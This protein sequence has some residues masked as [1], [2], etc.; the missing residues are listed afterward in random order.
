MGKHSYYEY[1]EVLGNRFF[2][3]V[4]LPKAEGKFPTV[5][6][7]NPYVGGTVNLDEADILSECL[8]ANRAYLDRGYAVV[9]QHTR[10]QG[11]ST[12]AFVPYIHEREDTLAL[13]EWIRGRDF[14]N[15]ELYPVGGSYTASLHYT[16]APFPPDIKGAVFEVQDYD[17]YRLWYRNGQMRAG[18]ANWHF[19]LYKNKCGLNKKFNMDSFSSLPLA[20]LSERALGD[21]AEDFEEMLAAPNPRDEFWST[22]YGGGEAYGATDNAGIPILLTTGYND[23]YVGGVFDMW[24]RMGEETRRQSALLV[25]PYNHGDSYDGARGIPFPMGRR[26]EA[27]GGTYA[28]DW[29]DN[30]RLGT[31]LPYEKGV[32]TYY[33]AFEDGWKSDFYSG[34]VSDVTVP[35]GEGE[36]ILRYDPKNPPAFSEEGTRWA[37]TAGEG[38]VITIDTAPFDHDT[39]V[40]GRMRAEISLSADCPDTSLY[41]RLS[42]NRGDLIYVLRHD[43]T[44]IGYSVGGYRPNEKITLSF[45]FDEYAF[46]IRSGDRLRVDIASTDKNTYVLHTNKKGPY[47]LQDES[48]VAEV[49]IYLGESRIYLPVEEKTK[50]RI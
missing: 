48:D 26:S 19:S 30:V 33:R 41:L 29:L 17:R 46:L 47:H 37:Y 21:V 15:G 31:P 1:I 2:T 44:S 42:I 27:F 22:R 39:F 6:I 38:S 28:I 49:K 34:E 18:H 16:A 7:R 23:F 4:L 5:V 43:I 50:T 32:I 12:G 35:L 14:Y 13:Y 36:A 40:K 10:G 20:G 3:M 11:K 9:Y 8:K 45:T 24:R 25:S